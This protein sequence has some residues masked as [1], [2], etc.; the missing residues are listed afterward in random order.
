MRYGYMHR[1]EHCHAL[2]PESTPPNWCVDLPKPTW[3][4]VEPREKVWLH[5]MPAA[6]VLQRLFSA[7][8]AQ[9]KVSDADFSL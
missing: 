9:C 4:H 7:G 8:I 6:A 2:D 5:G 1:A 3:L